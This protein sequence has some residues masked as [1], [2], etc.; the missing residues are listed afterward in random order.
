MMAANKAVASSSGSR[1][2]QYPQ[3]RGSADSTN[4]GDSAAVDGSLPV[5]NE[6]VGE[7]AHG[8]DS[9]AAAASAASP[10]VPPSLD[11][12]AGGLAR[13]ASQSTI[14]PVDT[15]KVRM[16]A[17]T[18]EAVQ[19]TAVAGSNPRAV[20]A[21]TSIALSPRVVLEQ[22]AAA[23][24]AL[25]TEIASL[26]KGVGGAAGGAGLAIGAYFAFYGATT[27]VLQR[28]APNV[29]LGVKAFVA[30]A[31]GAIGASI[32]KVPASV[33]IRGVQAGV[34][35]NIFACAA[36]TVQSN[37]I[38]GLFTGYFPT[39]IEDVPDMAVKFAAYETLRQMH[40][41]LMNKDRD[42]SSS[43]DNLIMGGLAGAAAAAATTPLDVMKTRMMVSA[44][45]KPVSAIGACR[46]VVLNSG[47]RGLFT[48][49]WPR[50]ASNF[51]NSGIFFVFFEALRSTFWTHQHKLSVKPPSLGS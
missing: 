45:T 33:C 23:T 32:I 41:Q 51:I 5:F 10:K 21:A 46:Q 17:L 6:T 27:E 28:Q 38:R 26:Y 24:A 50:T 29:P 4:S 8:E 44:G 18:K 12:L 11:V 1:R 49:W 3:H 14:H 42:D 37:G 2:E 16:Q 9:A 13:A 40:A 7:L 36:T 22:A 43:I 20:A 19:K 35:S 31:A 39:L 47:K 15:I 48:G 34:H 25:R 30:G